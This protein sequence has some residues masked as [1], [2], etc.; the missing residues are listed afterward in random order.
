MKRI[1]HLLL[2]SYVLAFFVACQPAPQEKAVATQ[3]LPFDMPEVIIPTFRAD[4]F[5]LADYGAVGDG[6]VLSTG[7][8]ASAIKACSAAG[9][10]VVLVPSGLW[11]TGPITLKSNVNLHLQNGA[12]IQFTADLDQFPLVESFFEGLSEVRCQ[13][14]INGNDL[15]NV[16]IT[17]KGIIDGNGGHW[18]QVKKEKLTEGQWNKL[19][20]SGGVVVRGNRWYPS[21]AS[22]IGNEKKELLPKERTLENM[23]PFKHYLRPVMVSLVNC[24]KVLLEGVT[25]QNS[26]AWNVN[27]LM[28]EHITLRDLNIRN[29]W[30]SQNGDGLDLESCRIGQVINCNF[31]VGDDAIC[32]KSGKDEEGRKRGKPTELIVI[33]DCTVYHGHGGFVVGSEMSGGVRKMFVSNCTFIGTDCGL[34]FK[35]LRGR[36][37]AVEDIYMENIRMTNIP[38]EAIRFNLFYGGKSPEEDPMTGDVVIDEIPVD[39][40]TPAFRNMHFRNIVCDGAEKAIMMQGI[41][42]MPVENLLFE[43]M[44]IRSK[45]GITINYARGLSFKNVEL[46][47]ER[48]NAARITNSQRI[49]FDGF[50]ASGHDKLFRISG[51]RT[52]DVQIKAAEGQAISFN[53]IE[54]LEELKEQIKLAE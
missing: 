53:D 19:V 39:E 1:Q 7:A 38:T 26:P 37:G 6:S 40:K 41:P 52:S 11:L 27:P 15:E 43:N 18:R 33:R 35:S 44:K 20:A 31:D 29:P 24:T 50:S 3:Q 42:E 12:L 45:E 51:D 36:G 10:G 9:G 32:I 46:Q 47:V 5:N 23:E 49:S 17:G 30:F 21:E 16:A 34:R 28:C 14:P 25:F 54:Y 22:M 13:S 48:G 2:L 4:T 8:F